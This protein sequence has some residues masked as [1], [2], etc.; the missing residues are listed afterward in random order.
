MK[1]VR[2]IPPDSSQR[3]SVAIGGSAITIDHATAALRLPD[4]CGGRS[5]SGQEQAGISLQA[6]AG[7]DIVRWSAL[8][9]KRQSSG[10]SPPPPGNRFGG[11]VARPHLSALRRV[12]IDAGQVGRRNL[13]STR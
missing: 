10:A 5:R 9:R 11:I 6:I 1:I 2:Q 3:V 13:I 4:R 12:T 8:H 7:Y